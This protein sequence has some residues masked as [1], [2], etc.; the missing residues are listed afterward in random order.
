[1]S[2][3]S[4]RR[5]GEAETLLKSL[6]ARLALTLMILLLLAGGFNVY[7]TLVTT[8]Q[9]LQEV[10]QTMN[11][12][13]AA[14]IADMKHD[15]LMERGEIKA[16]GLDQVLHWMMVVNPGPHFYLL[17]P[18]GEILAYDKMA[19][20]PERDRVR[21][22]PI[23][24]FLDQRRFTLQQK[25]T[26]LGEDPRDSTQDKVFSVAQI[27]PEGSPQALL[28]IV[29]AS[30]EVESAADRLRNSYILRLST[31]NGLVYLGVVLLS[32][33]LGFG[34]LTRP[35]R[36]LA[37][38]M[39]DFRSH[40]QASD[41]VGL[42]SG[43]DEVQL[44]DQTFDKMSQRIDHQ[45][46]Q[47]EAMSHGHKEL[48]AN[49]SHDLR[50]PIAS[51][52]GYLDTLALK[53]GLSQDQRE[54]FLQIAVRQSERL[55][56]LVDELFELTKLDAHEVEPKLERFRLAELVQDNVQRFQL[57]AAEQGVRLSAEFD[58]DL[59]PVR[60]D[61]GL[62]ERALENLIDNALKFTDTGGSVT[63]ELREEPN[64]LHVRVIDTGCGIA[65]ED[66]PHI[67]D[68]YYRSRSGKVSAQGAGL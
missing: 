17:S 31:R 15:L 32:G 60:V 13:L 50:T 23:N 3:L 37:T 10:N 16:E 64:Q 24:R 54:E 12:D 2:H 44:L 39:Q 18:G 6:H 61:V 8:E 67:F 42:L 47:I 1:M 46:A 27:P 66:L 48:I 51:L 5:R 40:E 43:N 55:G 36:R 19:G 34:L 56:R 33:L 45:M 59:P 9:Y 11:L 38:R 21:L 29:L 63:V 30:H 53:Q 57:R 41:A 22:E 62:M 68:R 58:P 26:I 52:R 25:R 20:E 35:L 28:Y 65:A 49:V 4:R 7:S 14:N